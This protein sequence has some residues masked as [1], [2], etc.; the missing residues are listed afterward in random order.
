[1]QSNEAS[2][3]LKSKGTEAISSFGLSIG[4]AVH[5]MKILRDTLYTDRILAVLREYSSNAWDAHREAGKPE[6]PID[7]TMPTYEK[8][9]LRIRDF[10]PGLSDEDVMTIY[11]QYGESTKR[12]TDDQVGALGIG[13]KSAFSY[14]DQFTV[15]SWHNGFKRIYTAVLDKT[16]R[17]E[18]RRLHEERCKSKETGIE[19]QVPVQNK[20]INAFRDKAEW[21]FR[22]FNPQPT[23][24]IKLEKRPDLIEGK[25]YIDTD[26]ERWVAVMGCVPYRINA[27][28]VEG[29]YQGYNGFGGALYVEI[30][31]V[32]INASREELKYTD[33]TVEILQER[34]DE[35][36]DAHLEDFLKKLKGKA[37]WQRRLG[38]RQLKTLF[39]MDVPEGM[40]DL[41]TNK[42]IFT[43]TFTKAKTFQWATKELIVDPKTELV[44]HNTDK[45]LSGYSLG[46][47]EC[48]IRPKPSKTV[49]EVERELNTYLVE[50]A[51]VGIPITYTENKSWYSHLSKSKRDVNPK[52]KVK[53][54]VLDNTHAEPR[55]ERWGTVSREPTD[56]DV[57]V[58]IDHFVIL[59]EGGFTDRYS[60]ESVYSLINADERLAKALNILDKFP[61]IYAYKSASI[62]KA[63]GTNYHE[64]R[65]TFFAKHAPA[66]ARQNLK[67]LL[68]IRRFGWETGSYA[69]AFQEKMVGRLGKSHI[70]NKTILELNEAALR[71]EVY[72]L[73]GFAGLEDLMKLKRSESNKGVRRKE[74]LE[75]RYP[76]LASYGLLGYLKNLSWNRAN[77]ELW[78][79]YIKLVDREDRR[80]RAHGGAK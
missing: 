6:L 7:V 5:I 50:N 43:N 37:S 38:V 27:H 28:K 68:F 77:P 3:D 52:Y 12:N 64:W 11:T 75:K 41:K 54:F 31:D 24:N 55:S 34:M 48:G 2:R 73:S 19:I 45:T 71:P 42:T 76:L 29:L 1:M 4:N 80:K 47:Y 69:Q 62:G 78:A 36:R 57:Y 30:G 35:L 74:A 20:D 79:E 53:S 72:N 59:N 39:K 10:G 13:C 61:K 17:G 51:L 49:A 26:D 63:K 60:S 58:E 25:G 15:T 9:T 21:L 46:A 65:K 32:E 22:F 66:E 70:I 33:K 14:A 23:I 56:D 8:P 44:I 40:E 67:L 18:M 16:S